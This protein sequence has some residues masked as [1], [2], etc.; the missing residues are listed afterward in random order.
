MRLLDALF[1]TGKP[2]AIVL[3][4][5]SAVALGSY[6]ERAKAVL[7][8]WYPGEQ[9]G[10]AIAEVLGGAV[11][12]SGRLPVTFYA[13]LDQL[14]PFSDYAMRGRTY[15][16]FQGE[17]EHRF[18][19]GLSYTRFAYSQLK[20]ATP[21]LQAGKSQWVSVSVRNAGPVAGEEVV[22]LYLATPGRAQAPVRS[23]KGFQ[24]VTLAPGETRTVRFELSSRDLALADPDGRLRVSAA[25]YQVWVGG[26]Q[27]GRQT[28][29]QGGQFQVSGD[30]TLDR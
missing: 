15:R 23:L 1:A 20:I 4:T 6:G 29:G 22:Q 9:G 17:P 16:Y 7:Q 13:S 10:Q 28:P 3:E 12:P 30:V 2:V 5:G 14:P 21:R 27:P 11:N 25:G 19:D 18:G 8:A 24:R 26:G